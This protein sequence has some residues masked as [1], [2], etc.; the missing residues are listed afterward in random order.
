MMP[1]CGLFSCKFW[2]ANLPPCRLDVLA[3]WVVGFV[4]AA[5]LGTEFGRV[6]PELG[7]TD[8]DGVTGMKPDL[9]L[10]FKVVLDGALD[11][12][13]IC[14]FAADPASN[15]PNRTAAMAGFLRLAMAFR[16]TEMVMLVSLNKRRWSTFCWRLRR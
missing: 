4:G 5:R 16:D 8:G 9:L 15:K 7:T 2:L 3:C 11:V 1:V 13:F 10:L 12:L 14:A 6:L